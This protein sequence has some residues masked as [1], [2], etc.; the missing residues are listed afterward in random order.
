M[1][2]GTETVGAV[3]LFWE[4]MFRIFCTVS[5]Q[6]VSVRENATANSGSPIKIGTNEI[7][8]N[9]NKEGTSITTVRDQHLPDPLLSYYTLGTIFK[10]SKLKDDN[11]CTFLVLSLVFS[12]QL[13]CVKKPTTFAFV[14]PIEKVHMQK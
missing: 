9:V 7:T 4:Y 11:S 8:A 13:N 2:V 10:N 3:F 5:L 6:C 12:K 1:N 14:Q